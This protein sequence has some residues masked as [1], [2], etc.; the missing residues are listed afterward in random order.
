MSRLKVSAIYAIA[1]R[2]NGKRYYGSSVDCTQRKWQH[3]SALKNNRHYNAHLQA[4]RLKSSQSHMGNK[5]PPH[6]RLRISRTMTGVAKSPE[7]IAKLRQRLMGH[8]VSAETRVKIR[9]SLRIH[10]LTKVCEFCGVLFEPHHKKRNRQKTCSEEC[11]QQQTAK[12][13]TRTIPPKVCPVCGQ[14]FT[15]R[16]PNHRRQKTCSTQCAHKATAATRRLK[17]G[18]TC[19]S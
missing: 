7:S 11:R 10:P 12:K 8:P 19:A 9:D 2:I 6:V 3:W 4:A 18:T 13:R 14:I 17:G 1:N 15:P 16:K 5:Q